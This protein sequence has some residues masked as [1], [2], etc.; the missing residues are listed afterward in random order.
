MGSGS[1]NMT[2]EETMDAIAA[3]NSS[4]LENL[5]S[6]YVRILM[7]VACQ[8]LGNNSDAED[9]IH[10][11]FIEVWNCAGNYNASRG[12]VKS[13]LVLIT[14]S[15]A[16]DRIRQLNLAR[17]RGM[18]VAREDE[19]NPRNIVDPDAEL[20]D[21]LVRESVKQLKKPVR[22]VLYLNYF[23]GFTCQEISNR[24]GIPVGTVKSRLRAALRDLRK[25]AEAVEEPV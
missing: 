24:L 13:W 18:Q 5:Y 21:T 11:V 25:N 17:D 1:L 8:I 14:R 4:A 20:Q 10:D 15:R 9:L 3:G 22:E 7:G 12:S 19:Q 23:E 2:D 6:R 16:I